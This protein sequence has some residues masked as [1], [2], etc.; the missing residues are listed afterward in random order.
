MEDNAFVY[1]SM[2]HEHLQHWL[3]YFPPTQLLVLPSEALFE[4]Q[5]ISA[6]F[7]RLARFLGLPPDG[8]P[9]HAELLH[10]ASTASTSSAP[11]ENG[12]AY[13]ADAPADVAAALTAFLCAKNRM[14]S[15]LLQRHRLVGAAD[16][17]PWLPRAL[18]G[19]AGGGGA[20]QSAAST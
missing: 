7:G 12:R 5:S 18:A 9:V 17:I 15:E 3:K 13:V 11:H 10:T 1:R 2:Y 14:L 16:E 8:P 4:P 19:C 6:A 20:A